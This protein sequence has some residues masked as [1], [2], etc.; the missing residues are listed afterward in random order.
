MDSRRI[1]VAVL[2]A[3]FA[4]GAGAGSTLAARPTRPLPPAQ[5]LPQAERPLTPKEQAISDTKVAAAL[6]YVASL[7]ASNF[8]LS[9]LSCAVPNAPPPQG[10]ARAADLGVSG[11]EVMDASCVP[12]AQLP[13]E[14]RQ[15]AKN[16]Y[17]GPAVGQVISNYAWTMKAG[18]NKH[19]QTTIATWMKT[20]VNGLTN[21]PELAAGLQKAT[22]GGPRTPA[23]WAWGVTD[24][25]DLDRN[26][27]TGDEL[28]DFVVTAISSW[29]MPLGI[30]VKPHDKNSEY[31]L[32]SW[33]N[34][35]SSPGHW[36]AAYGWSG[37]GGL[38]YARVY[39]ADSSK[40]QG[41]G[42]GKY[43]NL[44]LEIAALIGEHTGRFVW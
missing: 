25:R 24:L 12:S 44:T 38:S 34:V 3:V 2:T 30:P 22:V 4:L 15:Q 21:A 17:C 43:W 37:F 13:V 6:T 8:G 19:S 31:R 1:A 29:K 39:F 26:S 35:V 42:T 41:G 7:R 20:D 5:P 9:S 33:P 18:A 28:H 36:I 16:H 40:N 11:T 14:A 10:T 27:S 32:S 23:N